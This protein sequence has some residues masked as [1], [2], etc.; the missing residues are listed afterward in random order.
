MA[1]FPQGGAKPNPGES[2][3]QAKAER[4]RLVERVESGTEL[5]LARAGKPIA[6]L[7]RYRGAVR[8]GALRSMA[9]PIRM[10]PAFARFPDD[11]AEAP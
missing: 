4:A 6:R 5:T 8:S 7:V 10:A 1:A 9:G 3:T 2:R 11:R